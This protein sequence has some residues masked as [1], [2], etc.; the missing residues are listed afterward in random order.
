GGGGGTSTGSGSGSAVKGGTLRAG[1]V[2]N[3]DHIDPGLGY[4]NESWEIL[5]ATNNGL[6]TFKKAAGGEGAKIVPDIAAAMPTVTNGGLTFTFTVRPNVMFSAPV[7]RAVTPSD[8]KFTIERLFRLDSGGVGFYTGIA[9]ADKYAKSRKGGISGIVADD[10]AGTI[11]FHLTQPDGTFLEYMAM[12]FT[13]VVPKGTPA[14]DISTLSRWRVAT[15]PYRVSEYVPKD[16]ITMVRNPSFHSWTPDTPDGNL[17]KIQV[18]V[19]VT[20]EQ[21]V[22]EV[23]DGTLD[24]YFE[25]VAPDRLTELKARYPSQVHPYARNNI[26]FFTL[27]TRK[28][29]TNDVRVRK[30]LNYAVDR[31]A[32]LKVFGGQGTP[33]ENLIPPGFGT[34]FVKHSFYPHDM[35]KALALVSQSGTKG[36]AVQVWASNT[37]PQPK[38]AQYMASVLDSLGYKATVKTLDEG[39]YYDTV[40]TQKGDPQVS[41]NDWNQDFPE[42]EDFL[43]VLFNGEK[44]TNVGNNNGS[45]VNVPAL[46]TQMNAARGMPL[47]DARNAAWAKVDAALM[48]D[49]APLV[50]FLNRGFPKFVSPKLHG[51]VFNGTY[52]ELFPAMWLAK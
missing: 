35:A 16:H 12:P 43:D 52:F 19:G 46:N 36:M 22:N 9:G 1:I 2:D 40:A 13:F 4:T 24:W 26:T 18:Q 51:L 27:N 39:V 48:R 21:A 49:S 7:S 47:G 38:A 28:P 3:P 32:L 10:S 41:Y 11:T 20:P 34:A 33:S 17:D 31:Q 30:A 42:G 45:N 29:P 8:F 37:D 15:G 50:T 25:Q 6:L 5:E 23:A 44:I 14:K